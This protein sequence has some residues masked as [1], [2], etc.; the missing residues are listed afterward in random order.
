MSDC[1]SSTYENESQLASGNT[2][3]TAP[4]ATRETKAV[5]QTKWIVMAVL[6]C[7]A[8][9][10][11]LLTYRY[12]R[13]S[14]EDKFEENFRSSAHKTLEAIGNSIEKTL[15]SLDSLT[16]S[17]VSNARVTNQTW[18]FVTVA[19]FAIR[20]AKVISISDAVFLS[21][22][23]VVTKAKRGQWEAYCVENDQW[24]NSSIGLQDEYDL[25]QGPLD[26][27]YGKN[28][29]IWGDFG[30]IPYDIE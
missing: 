11:A 8:L 2:N 15:K 22:M 18:P 3:Q 4:I 16:V 14:E 7:S 27:A 19:D 6:V 24:L 17:L 9:G 26:L 20:A 1:S 21:V 10:V 13:W 12:I 25:Y 23:P 29:I 30:D 5:S 28:P